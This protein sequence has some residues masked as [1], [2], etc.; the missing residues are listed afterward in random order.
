DPD[1]IVS[2]V[3]MPGATG[4]DL[5]R[6]L[7]QGTGRQVPVILITAHGTIDDAVAAMKEGATD[8]LTKP[9]DH[10]KLHALLE[11][12]AADLRRGRETR[13]LEEHL[14]TAGPLATLVGS[15]EPMQEL[16]RTVEL[17]ASSDASVLITGESGT[18]KEVVAHAIHDLSA[19]RAG[20]WLAVN[21]AA[22]PESLIESE[23]FGHERGAFT[24]A[25]QARAGC[26]EQATGGTLFLD[27]IAEMPI[28]LQPRL[29]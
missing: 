24:G 9:L 21:A 16:R 20:P 17:V 23:L 29:L 8:F 3:V 11:G 14:H 6:R 19:R 7:G 26:F 25:V 1:V 15:S 4:I 10:T 12:V 2:D 27:E 22:I 18:G 28:A 5:L 13:A